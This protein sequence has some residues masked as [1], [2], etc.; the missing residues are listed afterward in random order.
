VCR[1]CVVTMGKVA[2]ILQARGALE[3]ALRIRREEQLP[4]YERLGEAHEQ[5]VCLTNLAILRIQ[6]YDATSRSDAARLLAQAH[7][8]FRRMGLPDARTVEQIAEHY[9]LP[10]TTPA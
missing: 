4:V 1:S 2:D 10:L 3:E 5:A 7:R 6:Q 9:E 8:D